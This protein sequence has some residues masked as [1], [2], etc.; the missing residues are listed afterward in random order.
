V[1]KIKIPFEALDKRQ[2]KPTK[3]RKPA[4]PAGAK[5]LLIFTVFLEDE[6]I[7]SSDQLINNSG[8]VTPLVHDLVYGSEEYLEGLFTATRG[9]RPS[10]SD[11]IVYV[12]QKKKLPPPPPK[13]TVT[14]TPAHVA[15]PS[16]KPPRKAKV[17]EEDEA[18]ELTESKINSKK[19]QMHCSACATGTCSS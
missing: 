17:V 9:Q 7:L 2:A 10:S 13:P 16:G 3:S 5:P 11:Y 8:T 18:E 19:I 4:K 6:R 12:V 15:G 14:A 1:E